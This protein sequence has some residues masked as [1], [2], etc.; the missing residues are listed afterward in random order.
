M[1]AYNQN[2]SSL[3]TLDS[4]I[5]QSIPVIRASKKRPDE[6]SIFNYLRKEPRKVIIEKTDIDN[7]VNM[8]LAKN[9]VINK[10]FNGKNSYFIKTI[11]EII[12][13]T[14]IEDETIN[15]IPN[16][17]SNISQIESFIDH[18]FMNLKKKSA[19]IQSDHE[20]PEK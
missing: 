7:R 1:T 6:S 9:K 16:S 10:P 19:T 17:S 18:T 20:T 4:L 8:L 2:R 5:M 12:N 14:E 13:S 11:E 3:S 15:D